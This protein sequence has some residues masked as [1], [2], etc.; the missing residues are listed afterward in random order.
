[1]KK[2]QNYHGMMAVYSALNLIPIKRLKKTWK[3]V[4]SKIMSL[5]YQ[6]EKLLDHLHGFKEHMKNIT[7]PCIPYLG[8]ITSELSFIEEFPTFITEEKNDDFK[9]V[10]WDKMS[11][12]SNCFT[13]FLRFQRTQ[14]VL[15]A[16]GSVVDFSSYWML[17]YDDMVVLSEKLES[18]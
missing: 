10:N 5:Y 15:E 13:D 17:E 4:P 1:M 16:E 6:A 2:L 18:R 9:Y 12:L 7:P 14:Y 8:L 11:M 3:E